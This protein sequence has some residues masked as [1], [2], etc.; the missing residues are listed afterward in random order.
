[1][2]LMLL[3][4]SL[5]PVWEWS[6][7]YEN[8]VQCLPCLSL[9]SLSFNQTIAV[10]LVSLWRRFSGLD[11]P[12]KETHLSAD[13]IIPNY[14]W[15]HQCLEIPCF[16]SFWRCADTW[17]KP[18]CG[19]PGAEYLLCLRV[20]GSFYGSLEEL[21]SHLPKSSFFSWVNCI[22]NPLCR[23]KQMTRK[24]SQDQSPL[25]IGWDIWFGFFGIFLL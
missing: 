14:S 15:R 20:V 5:E 4:F 23:W 17:G 11:Q 18:R 2:Q 22:C 21:A 10:L 1:M 19:V 7:L 12:I 8:S 25:K 6:V 13:V 16:I 24:S 9:P 3:K